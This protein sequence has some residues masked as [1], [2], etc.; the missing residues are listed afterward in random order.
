M[1]PDDFDT[2]ITPEELPQPD[3]F[4]DDLFETDNY[5]YVPDD[6]PDDMETGDYML[7]GGCPYDEGSDRDNWEDQQVFNDHEW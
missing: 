3:E 1:L 7:G 4:I 2:Q 6:E 5:P